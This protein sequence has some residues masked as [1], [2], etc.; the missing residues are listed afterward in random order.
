MD[1]LASHRADKIF[2]KVWKATKRLDFKSSLPAYI[3]G[4]HEPK[5][6]TDLFLHHFEVDPSPARNVQQYA[7][8]PVDINSTEEAT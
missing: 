6:I 7:A 3:N 2:V 8:M 1:K 5:S 4:V